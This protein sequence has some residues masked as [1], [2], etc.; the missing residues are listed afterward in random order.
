M[1]KK[2][3]TLLVA[4]ALLASVAQ[5]APPTV[6]EK[7]VAN[8]EAAYQRCA[9]E[10]SVVAVDGSPGSY[11]VGCTLDHVMAFADAYHVLL[12]CDVA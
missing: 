6:C 11:G 7:A 10:G 5:A 9:R 1:T 3:H 8:A 4:M 2:T 12:T